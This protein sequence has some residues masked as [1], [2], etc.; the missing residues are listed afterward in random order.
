MKLFEFDEICYGVDIIHEIMVIDYDPAQEELK[1]PESLETLFT[2][3]SYF[4]VGIYLK[5]E[6]ANAEIEQIYALGQDRF[7]AVIK[8]I[9]DMNVWIPKPERTDYCINF[10]TMSI[11]K[12]TAG[13]TPDEYRNYDNIFVNYC[14]ASETLEKIKA[15]LYVSRRG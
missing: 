1:N 15:I 14:K 4:K 9:H 10:E 5:P 8:E 2:L 11:E 6:Y 13:N 3:K 7:L 12:F